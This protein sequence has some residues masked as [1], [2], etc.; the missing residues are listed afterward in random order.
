MGCAVGKGEVDYKGLFCELI[1]IQ[2]HGAV[3]L[4]T[5]YKPQGEIPEEVLKNPKGSAI[6]IMGDIA[7]AECIDGLKQI[8]EDAK[9]AIDCMN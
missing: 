6:S 1:R 8:I 9:K 3:M 4:E 5:H 2:Y 7:S